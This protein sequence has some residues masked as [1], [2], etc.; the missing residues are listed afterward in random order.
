MILLI[1]F[2]LFGY[3][4]RQ[5]KNMSVRQHKDARFKQPKQI[6]IGE[7]RERKKKKDREANHKT[8]S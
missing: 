5:A 7:G 8:D 2:R 3:G 4:I 1:C 6:N